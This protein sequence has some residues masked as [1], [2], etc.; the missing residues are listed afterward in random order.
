MFVFALI[1]IFSWWVQKLDLELLYNKCYLQ[2]VNIFMPTDFQKALGFLMLGR[3]NCR[4]L[5]VINITRIS[6]NI[7]KLLHKNIGSI[8]L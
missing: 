8:L 4:A 5:L 6:E 1:F 3:S 7:F 2:V